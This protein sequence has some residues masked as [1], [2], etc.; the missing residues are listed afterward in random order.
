ASVSVVIVSFPTFLFVT[1][2]VRRKLASGDMSARA[3]MRRVLTYGMLFLLT[4]SLVIDLIVVIFLL[5]GGELT[6][7]AL[8]KGGVTLAVAGLAFLYYL[9]ELREMKGAEA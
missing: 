6:S 2:V 1:S 4:V 7:S 8:I 9:A 5:L 3:L